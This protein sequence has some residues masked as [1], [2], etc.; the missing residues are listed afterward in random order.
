M[1]ENS[2][3]TTE[4]RAKLQEELTFLRDVKRRE[5]AQNLKA[6]VEDG[7][8]TENSAYDETKREQAFVEGRIQE[9]E[10]ILANAQELD[11]TAAHSIA[12]LGAVITIVEDGSEPETYTIVGRTEADPARGRISNESPLGKALL[13]RRVGEMVDVTTPG[14]KL[15]VKILDID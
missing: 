8:I 12:A 6:A 11:I 1:V 10:A 7:D 3:L 15:Q 2:F 5:V 4:G 13:G 9:I 14:G